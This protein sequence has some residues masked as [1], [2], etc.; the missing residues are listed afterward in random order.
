MIGAALPSVAL[1]GPLSLPLHVGGG[2]VSNERVALGVF[3]LVGVFGGAHCIGMCGPLVTTYTR[4][5]ASDDAGPSWFEIRQHVL[6]NA[7][8]TASYA[9]LGGVFGLLGATLYSLAGLVLGVA[10]WLRIGLGLLVGAFVLATGASYLVGRG[11]L[12]GHVATPLDGA[13]ARLSARVGDW[14][15]S[16]RIVGLGVLHGFLPCPLLYPA[17]LYA[18]ARG[19]AATG[20]LSL[21]ALGLGTIP[22]LFLYGAVLGAVDRRTRT[23]LHRA[24]GVAFLLLGWMPV[25]HSLALLGVPVPH[26][27]LPYYQPLTP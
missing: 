8:R 19:N 17:F 15:D 3:V 7:G 9:L 5:F 1:P 4:A 16:S 14:A 18:F 24:L 11:D 12:L 27:E 6:F 13:F 23:R 2:L 25:A 21:A 10:G 20:A 22:A 26:V